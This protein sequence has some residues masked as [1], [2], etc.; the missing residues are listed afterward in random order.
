MDIS[1]YGND[2]TEYMLNCAPLGKL[3]VVPHPETLKEAHVIIPLADVS[4]DFVH[5]QAKKSLRAMAEEIRGQ[6]DFCS[7]FSTVEE[8][9]FIEMADNLVQ[10]SNGIEGTNCRSKEDFYVSKPS[11][12][13]FQAKDSSD[14]NSCHG[15]GLALSDALL[16]GS[17]NQISDSSSCSGR[18]LPKESFPVALVTGAAKRLGACIVRK[19]H[20]QGYRVVV[21]FNKSKTEAN[22]LLTE[23]NR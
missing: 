22:D 18:L 23:L 14:G 2:I 1:F 10:Q 6:K 13:M 9:V 5:P 19:L 12:D 21:H 11:T 3:R 4:P 20:A 17:V 7:L 8:K 16:R 15:N